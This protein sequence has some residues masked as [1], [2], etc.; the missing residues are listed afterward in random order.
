MCTRKSCSL[1]S[2]F[3][4]NR[5]RFDTASDRG[6]Y[7]SWFL[8]ANHPNK[9]QGF[10][11]R[12]TLFAPQGQPNAAEGELWAVWFDG[13]QVVAGY[14]SVPIEQCTASVFTFDVSI[15]SASLRAAEAN[16]SADPIEWN[17]EMDG[18]QAPLLLLREGRYEASFPHAK[19]LVP[20]PGLKFHG[21]L[22]VSGKEIEIND[23]VGSQNHNWGDAHT[24]RY[25]WGQVAA[26]D[27][28]PGAFLECISAKTKLGP[29]WTPWITLFVLR[30]PE[31]EIS[32]RGLIAGTRIA[33]QVGRHSWGFVAPTL[34]GVV[35]VRMRAAPERFVELT[36]RNPPGG[37][38]MCLNSKTATCTV[39]VKRPKRSFRLTATDRAALEFLQ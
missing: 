21:R 3:E 11:I 23:W 27:D 16:G 9:P 24:D 8:R 28:S 39:E 38:K 15:G 5:P 7:E 12:Y 34:A 20:Q 33:A 32:S 18:A 14:A 29:L 35:D 31:R 25:V 19:S 26:F 13:D 37:T 10:W 17:L 4:P 2:V 1:R 36:Y 30:M 22:R 6:H